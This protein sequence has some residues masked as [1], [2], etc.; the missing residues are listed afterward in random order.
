MHRASLVLAL[1]LAFGLIGCKP[2]QQA[3]H[4]PPSPP[5][6][7]PPSGP[8]GLQ[9]ARWG[10]AQIRPEK[11]HFVRAIV[12]TISRNQ[13][14]YQTVAKA[15]GVPWDVVGSIHNMECGLSFRQHLFNGDPLTARTYHVPAGQPK[16]GSPPFGWEDSAIASLRFDDLDRVNWRY[17]E[18]WLWAIEK[19]NGVGYDKYHPDTPTPYLWSWTTIYTR[20]KYVADGQWSSTAV[21]E[22]CG[23]VPILKLIRE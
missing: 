7:P 5:P 21:S 9:A 15:T 19:Y 6:P 16:T 23:V 20:G 17:L 13:S 2:K 8:A 18:A 3:V 22:Q 11:V 10:K 12:A 4:P 14:R 1:I